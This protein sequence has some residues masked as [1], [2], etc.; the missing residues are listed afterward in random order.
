MNKAFKDKV[1]DSIKWLVGFIILTLIYIMI[2][3]LGDIIP[4][5]M[6]S[7]FIGFFVGIYYFYRKWKKEKRF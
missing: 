3:Q 2:Q 4:V 7:I 6:L 5:I 1:V